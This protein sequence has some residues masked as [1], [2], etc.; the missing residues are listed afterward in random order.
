MNGPEATFIGLGAIATVA[1]ALVVTT[2]NVVHGALYLVAVLGS[3]GAVFLLLGAEFIGWVQ[4]LIY[5]GAIVVLVLFAIMLTRAPMGRQATDNQQRP[6][7]LVVA[8]GVFAVLTW[9]VWHTF[10]HARISLRTPARIADV[11]RSLFS[12]FV[13]PFEAVSVLLLAALVGAIVIAR[14]D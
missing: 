14:R 3:I 6:V 7:A 8:G 5:V 2:R 12:G 4:I 13:L 1:G 10:G 9:L 11:G